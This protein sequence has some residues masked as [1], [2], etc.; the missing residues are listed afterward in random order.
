MYTFFNC[1]YLK[2]KEAGSQTIEYHSRYKFEYHKNNPA[3]EVEI[4]PNLTAFK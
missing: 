2:P 4:F 1:D 3:K